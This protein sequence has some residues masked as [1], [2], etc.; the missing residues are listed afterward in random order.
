MEKLGE[1]EEITSDAD[2]LD[3]TEVSVAASVLVGSTDQV[4]GDKEVGHHFSLCYLICRSLCM[5]LGTCIF[6]QYL[7]YNIIAMVIL[8]MPYVSAITWQPFSEV[9]TCSKQ[10]KPKGRGRS[11]KYINCIKEGGN[12]EWFACVT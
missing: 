7:T 8:L 12:M 4:A 11:W 3:P 9:T 1:L 10:N 6:T 5:W 2:S